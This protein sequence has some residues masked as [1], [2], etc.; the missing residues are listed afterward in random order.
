M[1]IFGFNLFESEEEKTERLDAA[2]AVIRDEH[3]LYR[4]YCLSEVRLQVA[5]YGTT[6]SRQESQD[7]V[8]KI[9][10]EY[11]MGPIAEHNLD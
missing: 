6:I 3:P 2:E 1:R 5:R 4:H 8:Q 9:R 7:L 10:D 11:G